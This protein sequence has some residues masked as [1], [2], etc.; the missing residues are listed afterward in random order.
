M[1]FGCRDSHNVPTLEQLS[2]RFHHRCLSRLLDPAAEAVLLVHE[3]R[4]AGRG[5]F[6]RS[7]AHIFDKLLRRHLSQ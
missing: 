6:L 2:V 3:F 7:G 5:D 1:L 4:S